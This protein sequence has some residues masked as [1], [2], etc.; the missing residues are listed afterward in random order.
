MTKKCQAFGEKIRLVRREKKT[1]AYIIFLSL[2]SEMLIQRN[3]KSQENQMVGASQSL[4]S[5]TRTARS[6]DQKAKKEIVIA[7]AGKMY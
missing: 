2:T 5:G 6:T 1:V 3:I 7:S 4:A